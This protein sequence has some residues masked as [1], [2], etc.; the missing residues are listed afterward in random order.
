MPWFWHSA[1]G[2]PLDAVAAK[3]GRFWL[4]FNNEIL[5]LGMILS[6]IGFYLL[7]HLFKAKGRL[8]ESIKGFILMLLIATIPSILA[9]W[10]RA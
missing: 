6:I 1:I 8:R 9:Y 3:F 7:F 5:T 4:Y 2:T 10:I